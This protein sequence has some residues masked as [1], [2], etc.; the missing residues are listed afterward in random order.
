MASRSYRLAFFVFVFCPSPPTPPLVL[1]IPL[2]TIGVETCHSGFMGRREDAH[3]PV[4]FMP[5]RRSCETRSALGFFLTPEKNGS[6]RTIAFARHHPA[7]DASK[8]LF[9]SAHW[10]CRG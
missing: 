7:P 1:V 6:T 2:L 9:D 10:F 5:A 4:N 3:S 8:T